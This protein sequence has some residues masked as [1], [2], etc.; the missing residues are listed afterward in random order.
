[1]IDY[2]R[3]II[4]QLE[5]DSIRAFV[6]SHWFDG[7][8]LDFGCGEQPHRGHILGCGAV[9]RGYDPIG[10]PGCVFESQQEA[11]LMPDML[12]DDDPL[13][14]WTD[15]SLWDAI[16]CTQVVQ[17]V[18]RPAALLRRFCGALK[19]DGALVLTYPTCWHEAEPEDLHRF[20]HAG[21][22]ALVKDAGF[23]V[24]RHER[25][26]TIDVGGFGFT[27]GGALIARPA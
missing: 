12:I 23:V 3:D 25:R 27:L 26:A 21:M 6:E 5:R 16:L 13:K 11:D 2:D 18:P 9:Y 8:V 20:T 19:T 4:Y 15:E 22:E 14:M 10:S 1:M 17:Y 24:E 7:R